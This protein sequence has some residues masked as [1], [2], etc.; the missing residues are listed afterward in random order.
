MMTFLRPLARLSFLI[1]MLPVIAGCT[2]TTDS[3][4]EAATA[5]SAGPV[6]EPGEL[7][8]E[9]YQNSFLNLEVPLISGWETRDHDMVLKSLE[10]WHPDSG[11]ESIPSVF[12]LSTGAPQTEEVQKIVTQYFVQVESIS[13][14]PE[15]GGDPAAYLSAVGE[16]LVT[17]AGQTIEAGPHAVTVGNREVQRMDISFMFGTTPGRQSYFSWAEKGLFV[18][19]V[20]TYASEE[21]W[22]LLSSSV[23]DNIALD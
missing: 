5:R 22:E 6:F 21:E 23:L 3:G 12:L 11:I 13:L 4:A 20:F 8:E 14:Y 17:Q 19:M 2:R 1:L 9:S 10:S 16:A 7:T 18:N 15:F